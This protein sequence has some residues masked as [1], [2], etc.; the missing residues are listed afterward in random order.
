MTWHRYYIYHYTFDLDIKASWRSSQTWFWSKRRFMGSY[1]PRLKPP[2][3]ANAQRST[4]TFVQ[5]MNEAID[6]QES[7]GKPWRPRL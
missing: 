7:V 6:A 4:H 3:S 1:P 5:M 2:P